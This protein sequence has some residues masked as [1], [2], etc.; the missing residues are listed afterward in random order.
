MTLSVDL[1][2][3]DTPFQ[4]SQ[5]SP[6]RVNALV[7][8]N[9]HGDLHDDR[10]M[11]QLKRQAVINSTGASNGTFRHSALVKTH[12]WLSEIQDTLHR[13]TVQSGPGERR[14]EAKY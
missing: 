11:R 10:S 7:L 1:E 13:E 8:A 2:S 4:V 12:E 5:K 6:K 9:F 3:L 14:S